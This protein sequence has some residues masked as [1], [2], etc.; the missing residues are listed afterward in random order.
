MKTGY[1]KKWQKMTPRKKAQA[2]VEFAL[3]LPF[4]LLVIFG[5]LEFGRLMY[6]WIIVENS[7][8]LRPAL[9]Y[10]RRIRSILLPKYGPHLQ[11]GRKCR[12]CT[13]SIHQGC[14][15]PNFRRLAP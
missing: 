9:C 1:M 13:N 11:S 14:S 6:A 12:H 4:L 8:A 5:I 3:A 2:M 10:N 7:A 15:S